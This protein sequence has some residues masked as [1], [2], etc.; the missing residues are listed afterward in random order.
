MKR[1][2]LASGNIW[3]TASKSEHIEP[4]QHPEQLH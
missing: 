2:E 3:K 4:M 1:L